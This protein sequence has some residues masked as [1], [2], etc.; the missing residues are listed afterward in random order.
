MG[1]SSGKLKLK[2]LFEAYGT[3]LSYLLSGSQWVV[4]CLWDVT[5]ADIDKFCISL[6]K[7]W[8]VWYLNK[9]IIIL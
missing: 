4:G 3:S 6:F 7:N 1:C 9:Y 8:K 2:G 5:D